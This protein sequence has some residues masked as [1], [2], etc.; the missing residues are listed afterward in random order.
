MSVDWDAAR[1]TTS[2]VSDLVY[3]RRACFVN[4]QM[5]EEED[6][7]DGEARTSS[8]CDKSV[9]DHAAPDQK[10]RD[11]RRESAMN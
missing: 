9:L 10:K 7:F 8:A 2:A 3:D 4:A 1:P 5:V 11:S 6:G